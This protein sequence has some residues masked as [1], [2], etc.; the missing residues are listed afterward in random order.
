[1]VTFEIEEDSESALIGPLGKENFIAFLKCGE[2][3][4]CHAD[5]SFLAKAIRGRTV[6]IG[7]KNQAARLVVV[8]A[9][10]SI[11]GSPRRRVR[12]LALRGILATRNLGY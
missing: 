6:K 3:L 10:F 5:P 9:R 4:A 12:F 1:M 7:R 8:S 11:A 2:L